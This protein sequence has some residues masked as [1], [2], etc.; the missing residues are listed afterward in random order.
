M[1]RIFVDSS[2]ARGEFDGPAMLARVGA[3]VRA[4]MD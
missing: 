4:K 3:G 2:R 1:D